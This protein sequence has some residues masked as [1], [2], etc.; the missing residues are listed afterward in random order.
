MNQF[1][2]SQ[3]FFDFDFYTKISR[4]KKKFSNVSFNKTIPFNFKYSTHFFLNNSQRNLE[5]LNG[6]FAL[7]GLTNYSST[8][9]YYKNQ[10]LFFSAEPQT[11]FY[12]GSPNYLPKKSEPFNNDLT[13]KDLSSI[14]LLNM[15]LYIQQSG[16]RVGY[17]NWNNWS[18]PGIHNSL[19]LSN[20]SDGVPALFISTSDPI[21]I[22]DNLKFNY[23]YSVSDNLVNNNGIDYY[24][25]FS[26]IK[27]SYNNTQI[28]INKMILS[29]GNEDI[30]WKRTDAIKTLYSSNKMKYWDVIS[31]LY[32]STEFKKPRMIAF[33]EIGGL[34]QSLI[35]R[36]N[37]IY[38]NHTQASIIG[39]RK[40]GIGKYSDLL[41]GLEH[42][43]TIQGPYYDV[44]P[45]PNWYSNKKY[46][47]SKLNKKLLGAHSGPDSD[48][49]LVYMGYMKDNLS[50][51][52]SYNYERHGVTY[53]FPPEVKF[54]QRLL[55][56]KTINEFFIKI[57]YETEVYENY[58]F[59][60]SNKNVWNEINEP[61]S[62]QRTKTLTFSIVKN[63]F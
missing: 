12:F 63:L 33:F 32:I 2:L 44:L 57:Y 7:K 28:G 6:K 26:E 19:T 27:L 41:W 9:F 16:I 51:I 22:S 53:H 60:N 40:Y 49:I 4:E 17:G 43:R 36:K 62:I 52:F 15:G 45:T 54:E 37:N 25:S 35:F 48:D 23:K 34:N 11:V 59:L 14:K 50:V 24:I 30:N 46:N 21:S 38:Q 39:V 18:G 47:Y 3:E 31:D 29:G 56:T 58:A 61:G 13:I 1:I 5:N 42:T 55:I 10:N 8:L 20:N